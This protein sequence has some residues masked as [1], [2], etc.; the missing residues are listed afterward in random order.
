MIEVRA[1]G[2]GRSKPG[3]GRRDRVD[4]DRGGEAGG[5]R[6]GLVG[7]RMSNGLWS[8]HIRSSFWVR[9]KQYRSRLHPYGLLAGGRRYRVR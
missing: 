7:A 5:W 6:M 3:W 4:W 2:K 8:P 1:L 9:Q